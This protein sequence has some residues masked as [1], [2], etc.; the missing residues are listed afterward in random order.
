MFVFEFSRVT[1]LSNSESASLGIDSRGFT[2]QIPIQASIEARSMS[3]RR[4]SLIRSEDVRRK[5]VSRESRVES[6]ARFSMTK[7]S[8]GY[9]LVVK[10]S[11]PLIYYRLD[12]LNVTHGN[13]FWVN[14]SAPPSSG[15][16]YP[17]G[18]GYVHRNHEDDKEP[19]PIMQSTGLTTD[20]DKDLL[21]KGN[22]DILK[23]QNLTEINNDYDGY[24]T[25]TIELWF[26]SERYPDQGRHFLYEEGDYFSGMSM[27]LH[28]DATNHLGWLNFYAWNLP[29][30][31]PDDPTGTRKTSPGEYGTA[32]E[33]PTAIT[34]Q[35][36]IDIVHYVA[37]VFNGAAGKYEGYIMTPES[38]NN[39]IE[40]CGAAQSIPTGSKLMWHPEVAVFGNVDSHTR[41]GTGDNGRVDHLL[42]VYFVG[43][44]DEIAIYDA[45]LTK[46]DLQSHATAG[47]PIAGSR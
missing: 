27:W 17:R 43:W 24:G 20:T 21:F 40:L 4:G 37:F 9:D 35:I 42:P 18:A 13:P 36:K 16:E 44:L 41:V 15:I 6:W 10:G 3:T 14:N 47:M 11:N 23:L 19:S 32:T 38:P 46:D 34:C 5:E 22:G 25:R 12:E 2:G 45:A 31:Y 8:R 7:R 29:G 28:Q 39:Q 33:A 30:F 1:S 26:H